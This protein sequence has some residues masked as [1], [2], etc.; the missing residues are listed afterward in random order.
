MA[1]PNI[2]NQ[3]KKYQE[4]NSRLN[5]YVALVE[6]IYDT[7]NLEAA[8]IAL[9]TEYDADSGTVFKFSDYPQTKKSIADIQAQFVDDIRSVIYRGTSDEWKN[10]NEVQDLM[11]DKVLKA[12]TATIDKEK[13]KVL[14]QTNSDALK[15]FQN[16]RDRGFD[17]SAKLWQQSTVYKEELEAAIS[18][19]IQK[20]TSAVAL[21][22]QISKHLLD[23]PSLQKDYKEKYGSAEH[24]KD[25]EYRS[26]RL[27]RSEINMAYRTA[28][29][30]RWKQ[31]D[32]VVGY[33]IKRSGR[34]FPCTVCE[35][36]A[37]K[38]PKDFTW[39]G[40]HPNCYSDDSEVLTNRGWKLFKDVFDDDLI[41]SLNPTNRTPEWVESTN[42]QCYRYNGDMIHFFNKSLDCLVTPEH[43]MVYLNKNDGRIK[44]CQAKEY[45]K[46]K[47]AFYRGCEY[48]SEDVAFY[49]IDNIKIPF[50]LFCEFMGYWLSDGSTMGN[51]GVVISQQE[52]EPARD[53]IVNCVKR[54]GFEPHLDKQ[55]VAFYSTPIRNYLKIFGK[56]S[57]KFIP[58]AIKNASVRQ[59]RIFLNAFMLCDG[60]RRPCKS[61]VGNHGT[62]FKSDKDEILYFTVSERMAGDLSELILKSGNRPSFSVNKAG[63]SHKSNGSIITSNY[64]C[65]SIRECYSVTATVFHKEIQHYDGFVYDLTLEKNHIMYIRRNGKCFW[66]SNCR[67]YKIPILK[68]EEEFWEWDGR[69]E[70]STESVNKVKDVPDSFKKWVLDNQRRID[71]AKKRD[72]LPYFL[73]DNP[74]FLKED[75]NIY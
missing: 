34:E 62:E 68:T 71:N 12:Y 70:A 64:D 49:E 15:A 35:S 25:C 31:M 37:G 7:L 72:T 60:Y 18:C 43:N 5:R 17:V 52:G 63:V 47:G 23:F 41:L 65:Y 58:S 8:K 20:G 6:Q 3:K 36:L 2:P 51:A 10:S 44:N 48:E 67:C 1:K 21:S 38:Y 73:K 28:E 59:I 50:D 39:V 75:K 27:A 22:K 14:Y 26:I 54:I 29:N 53:R 30:E 24:L 69:S 19:A 57:H 56:C 66:G 32:F 40:W 16:R 4:L 61:F 11:A 55:K 13:Y 42:R 46:G 45:T 33:E 9:N 74:S